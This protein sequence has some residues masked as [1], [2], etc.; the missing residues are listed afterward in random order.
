MEKELILLTVLELS[1]LKFALLFTVTLEK[2]FVL[3]GLSKLVLV[4]KMYSRGRSD[5]CSMMGNSYKYTLTLLFIV[6]G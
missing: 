2:L 6:F 4:R 1:L 3:I 5:I